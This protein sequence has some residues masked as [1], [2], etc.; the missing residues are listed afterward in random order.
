M[1][2]SKALNFRPTSILRF[3]KAQNIQTQSIFVLEMKILLSKSTLI[4]ISNITMN[5]QFKTLNF[6]KFN[7]IAFNNSV[8]WKNFSTPEI[9]FF[10]YFVS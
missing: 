5:P 1:T 10:R 2:S 9:Y 6:L 4:L 7:E 8:S 3:T